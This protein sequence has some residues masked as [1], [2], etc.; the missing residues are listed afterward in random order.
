VIGL[1]LGPMAE[2]QFRRALQI[3]QGDFSVFVSRP[4]SATL[5]AI[6]VLALIGPIVLRAMRSR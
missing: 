1:I 2:V 6:A 4:I 5:L 3:S